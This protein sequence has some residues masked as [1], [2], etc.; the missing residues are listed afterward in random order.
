VKNA[1]TWVL[2]IIA[3]IWLI[4]DPAGAAALAHKVMDSLTTLA[5]AL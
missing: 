2:L 3:L 4:N 5:A 1:L